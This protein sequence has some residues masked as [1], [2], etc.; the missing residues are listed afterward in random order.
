MKIRNQKNSTIFTTLSG[1]PDSFSTGSSR[2]TFTR[3]PVHDFCRKI[4]ESVRNIISN[5]NKIDGSGSIY[6]KFKSILNNAYSLASI[7]G[8]HEGT[9]TR[10]ETQLI[11][12]ITMATVLYVNSLLKDSRIELKEN[13]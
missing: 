6:E 4:L 2:S 10:E 1:Y 12:N 8:A 5:W 13:I 11:L 7:G 3:L 9:T